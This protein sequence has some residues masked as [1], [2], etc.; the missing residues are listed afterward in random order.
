M[1][2]LLDT[3]I[4]SEPIKSQPNQGVLTL[5]QKHYNRVATASIV[6]HEL[7]FGLQ[8]LA[9]SRKKDNLSVYLNEVIAQN[10]PILSYD[11]RAAAWHAAER[12][13]LTSLG[14]TPSFADSQIAAIAATNDLILVTRNTADFLAFEQLNIE[15][16][17]EKRG[18]SLSK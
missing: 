10:L 16:W 13:R 7:N 14:K 6:W 9:P 17:H 2:Y 15:N 5:L 4:L 12:A 3:N 8:R 11:D 1:K 18:T